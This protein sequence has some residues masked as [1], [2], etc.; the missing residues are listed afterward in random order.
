MIYI[1]TYLP[2]CILLHRLETFITGVFVDKET[3]VLRARE[4]VAR[5]TNEFFRKQVEELL[6]TNNADELNDRFYTDLEFGTGGLRGIIG[7]G[8]NRMNT[9]TVQR[10]TQ[11]IANYIKKQMPVETA[12]AVIAYDSRN[13]SD[14]FALDAALVFCANG[15][16]TYLF[17]GLRPTPELSFAVRHLK[18]TTGI[19]VTAS[20]NPPEYNGYKVYW[21][22][23]GQVVPPQDKGIILEVR[24]VTE[25]LRT[26]RED[27]LLSQ[28]LIMMDSIVDDAYIEMVKSQSIRP[29]LLEK[30]GAEVKIV[31]T[32]L[33]GSGAMPLSRVLSELGIPVVFV[34]EQQAPNGN[35][36]TVKYPNP[37]EA[38][39]LK[40][41][42]DL[43]ISEKADLVMATD[44]D[45]D[46][47]GIAVPDGRGGFS[48]VTGNQLGALLADYIFSGR[49]ETGTLP[50]NPVMIKTIV[51]TGL[52][53]RIA[54]D[55]GVTV[56]DVL[57]GFKY[58]ADKIRSFETGSEG[59]NYVFGGEESYGYLVGTSVR[60]K[61]AV[62]AAAM[63]AE[64][65]LFHQRR[66]KSICDRLDEI[67]LKYGYFLEQQVSRHFKGET[68]LAAI[69][70]LMKRLRTSPPVSIGG[71]RIVKIL[72]YLDGTVLDTVTGI[73]KKGI[74]LPPSN[75]I[76]F[77]LCDNG[78][79]TARPSGTE[80]KI[81]F[82]L[83]ICSEAGADLDAAKK[84]AA[85]RAAVLKEGINLLLEK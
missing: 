67:Y 13:F 70:N 5:E 34:K 63:T 82:Y 62:S 41:A 7:G 2:L 74:D 21:K 4:Y 28:K 84:D 61:D 79:V 78:M 85:G 76:Q 17:S 75:V 51:T 54:A 77:I 3:V 59:Y 37:E 48:L 26:T 20:H 52:Q 46:R 56:M 73:R 53:T 72:D 47:L 30:H 6:N 16:K 19:V 66:G 49:K 71:V 9:C 83:S 33:H 15:I 14:S 35:F 23:G 50:E 29:E 24:A 42:I 68:G 8:Y 80:P 40:M 18:A 69:S 11:G 55:Y 27:A 31:Y 45:A 81:K 65:A 38:D 57:T 64:M 22:D 32:P 10:A 60:D 1:I 36:P 25:I 43:G 12:S 44:P 58:I 39:A